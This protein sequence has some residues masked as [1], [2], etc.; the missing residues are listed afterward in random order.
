MDEGPDIKTLIMDKYRQF[1]DTLYNTGARNYLLINVPPLERTPA[2][3]EDNTPDRVEL[4]KAAVLDYNERLLSLIE[5]VKSSYSDVTVFHYDAH[6]LFNKVID[7]PSQFSL[8][9]RYKDVTTVCEAYEDGTPEP[10]TEYDE[11]DYGADEYL[12]SN[13]FHPTWPIHKLLAQ[14]LSELLS[15]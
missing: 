6:T 12:W 13:T 11:C 10:N 7:D 9:E 1:V 15:S 4:E 3:I 5:D 8:T 2:V 14:E